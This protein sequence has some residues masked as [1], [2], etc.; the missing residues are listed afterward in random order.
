MVIEHI[1]HKV[2]VITLLLAIFAIPFY[3]ERSQLQPFQTN[4]SS[5]M[6]DAALHHGKDTNT[7]TQSPPSSTTQETWGTTV[8]NSMVDRNT[9]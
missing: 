9:R 5:Y 8:G 6:V 3:V 7:D 1:A 4:I 2:A